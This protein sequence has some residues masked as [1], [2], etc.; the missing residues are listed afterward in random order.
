VLQIS[1]ACDDSTAHRSET[2]KDHREPK[3]GVSH[4]GLA[5][6][7]EASSEIG[8]ARLESEL[9]EGQPP[10]RGLQLRLVAPLDARTER[11]A[12]DDTSRREAAARVVISLGP[13]TVVAGLVW[14]LLQ[15]YRVTLFAPQGQGFWW[16]AVEP[17]LLIVLVGIVFHLIVARGLVRDLLDA[18]P[19]PEGDR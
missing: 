11:A 16:L 10:T 9:R 14:A 15:P 19:R 8:G 5:T 18:E 1:V 13:A 4:G 6:E 7:A 17:P 12:R 2:T 3:W